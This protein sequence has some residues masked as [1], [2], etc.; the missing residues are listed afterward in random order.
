MPKRRPPH[1]VREGTR[2]GKI[3]WYVRIGHGPRFR[4][5]G[6]YGT[7][8]FVDNCTLAIKQTQNGTSKKTNQIYRRVFRLV[9]ASVFTKY[10]VA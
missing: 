2:H 3:I 7:Q 4:V 6:T 9:V 5:E 10:A 1:L 8:E